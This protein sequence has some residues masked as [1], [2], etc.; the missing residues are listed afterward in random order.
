MISLLKNLKNSL[1]GVNGQS[2]Q[3]QGGISDEIWGQHNLSDA[4]QNEVVDRIH[5]MGQPGAGFLNTSKYGLPNSTWDGFHGMM[6]GLRDATQQRGQN[7]KM[8]GGPGL[9]PVPNT[10]FDEGQVGVTTGQTLGD[11]MDQFQNAMNHSSSP[12]SGAIA[13]LR[14]K[15]G[16]L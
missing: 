5:T 10:R 3:P 2:Y 8:V 12:T 1:L 7:L 11:D 4:R 6:M 13:N 15:F 16:L 14:R 9:G